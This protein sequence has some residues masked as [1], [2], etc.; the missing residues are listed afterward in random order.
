[1]VNL[2]LGL[3][4]LANLFDGVATALGYYC[5]FIIELNPLMDWLLSKGVLWFL[6]F[7]LTIPTLS[8]VLFKRYIDYYW[9]R[10]ILG[11]CL[12]TYLGVCALHVSNVATAYNS[13]AITECF[14]DE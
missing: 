2:I 12:A 6:G 3:L 13:G 1:M 4:V 14:T 10:V 11:V 5:G 7:K 8:V 9:V